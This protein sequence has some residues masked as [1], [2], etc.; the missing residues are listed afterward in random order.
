MLPS[1][2]TEKKSSDTVNKKTKVVPFDKINCELFDPDRKENQDTTCLVNKMAVEM[3]QCLLEELRDPKKATSDY[4]TSEDGEFSWGNTTEDE[5][6][7]CLG[8]MTTTD[9]AEAPFAALTRQM[10]QFGHILG[11]HALGVG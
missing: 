6:E 7:S 10:E 9:P 4:L 1:S 3:A 11:I 8:K 5:H 2:M